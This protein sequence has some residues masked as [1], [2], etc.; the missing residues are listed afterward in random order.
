MNHDDSLASHD[1]TFQQR[2]AAPEPRPGAGLETET[3]ILELPGC[4]AAAIR[5]PPRHAGLV[6]NPGCGVA[7]AAP[8][9]SASAPAEDSGA[10]ARR[11]LR[12]QLLDQATQELLH[13]VHAIHSGITIMAEQIRRQLDASQLQV[14]EQLQ[15]R[16]GYLSQ[17]LENLVELTEPSTAPV[18][19]RSRPTDLGA[20]LDDTVRATRLTA[21]ARSVRQQLEVAEELPL[22]TGDPRRIE[23]ML[24]NLTAY[25]IRNGSEGDCVSLRAEVREG[26]VRVHVQGG[27]V[28]ALA[29]QIIGPGA[30]AGDAAGEARP[31]PVCDRILLTT[32]RKIAEQHGG[33]LTVEAEA[34]GA[35]S[36]G[37]EL[38]AADSETWPDI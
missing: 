13:P 8:A 30:I 38:P 22:V 33:G 7:S 2:D 27:G 9:G 17:S 10:D 28:D 14:L 1:A 29:Q 36:F 4:G 11:R 19:P 16:I 21:R 12:Y 25:A 26:A 23:Q 37:V 15:E 18:Q 6:T 5:I 34:G 32:A 31:A 3:E 35:R 24:I 20:V